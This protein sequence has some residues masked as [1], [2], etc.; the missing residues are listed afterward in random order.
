M[1]AQR[2][3]FDKVGELDSES[4]H[5]VLL[6]ENQIGYQNLIYMVSSAWTEGFYRKPR[7]DME[8]LEQHHEGLIALSACLAG[9]IPR[10]LT[11]ND[12]RGAKEA[13]LRYQ[14]I[15]GKDNFFL[16]LHGPWPA[17]TKDDK[18]ADHTSFQRNRD[19]LGAHKRLSLYP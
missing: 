13:A 9:E 8:L 16:E 4:R 15:F 2:S 6:C 5:L 11:V 7:V 14:S 12:Y 10:A 1:S 19:P 3:R 17:G 18:S